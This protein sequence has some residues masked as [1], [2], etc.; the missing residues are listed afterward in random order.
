MAAD[1]AY[2]GRTVTSNALVITGS[3]TGR[4]EIGVG[5]NNEWG[6]DGIQCCAVRG[7]VVLGTITSTAAAKKVAAGTIPGITVA[8]RDTITLEAYQKYGANTMRAS[9]TYR[10]IPE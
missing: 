8:E 1:H 7:G 3:G 5:F 4:I 10:F 6:D 9:Q 2:P